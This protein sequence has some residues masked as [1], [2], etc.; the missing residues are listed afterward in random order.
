MERRWSGSGARSADANLPDRGRHCPRRVDA[1]RN[2]GAGRAGARRPRPP[3]TPLRSRG[4]VPARCSSTVRMRWAP[5]PTR[6]RSQTTSEPRQLDVSPASPPFPSHPS[7]SAPAAVGSRHNVDSQRFLRRRGSGSTTPS[8]PLA[9][10]HSWPLLRNASRSSWLHLTD[11]GQLPGVSSSSSTCPTAPAEAE[12][13]PRPH[14]VERHV[15]PAA[16]SRGAR[17]SG[18]PLISKS[19]R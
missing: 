7:S 13:P 17:A 3:S 10:R 2:T 14:T 9:H 5:D 11:C 15:K 8:R 6:S 18:E 4:S 16:A 1:R 12:I 19:N